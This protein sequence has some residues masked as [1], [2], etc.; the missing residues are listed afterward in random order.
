MDKPLP[1]VIETETTGRE[2]RLS[3]CE[4]PVS[5]AGSSTDADFLSC[6]PCWGLLFSEVAESITALVY[7]CL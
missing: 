2:K 5:C 3:P 4:L 1:R 6:H 7:H